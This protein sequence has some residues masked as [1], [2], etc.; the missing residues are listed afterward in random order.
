MLQ[1]IRL[2][3]RAFVIVGI[4]VIAAGFG[5][6]V[7]QADDPTANATM[8]LAPTVIALDNPTAPGSPNPS[9]PIRLTVTV[10][11]D[12]G[13]A[14]LPSGKQPILLNIY[15][16]NGGPLSPTT[17]RITSASDPSSSFVYD[18]SYFDNPMILTA[19]MGDA[20][21]STSIVAGNRLDPCN[22]P[23]SA[24][25]VTIPYSN[26]MR[27]LEHGFTVAVSVGGGPWHT[28]VE[29]DTGST[30]LVL[31]QGAMGPQAIGPG[32]PGS[33]EYY[34]SGY[35][36]VGNYWLTPVTIAIPQG[37]GVPKP[38][39]T[40]V[41]IEVFGIDKVECGSDV[42]SCT[43]PADQQKAIANFSLMGIGFDRGT[44][45]LSN[46]P[47]LQLAD[48][49]DGSMSPGY[50]IAPDRVDI[51]LDAADT[52]EDFRYVTLAPNDDMEGD[53]SGANG[54]FSFPAVSA[55]FCGSMLLDTGIDQMIFALAKGQRPPAVVDPSNS[56]LL[57]PGTAV[58]IATSTAPPLALFYGF[59][60]EPQTTS[61]T[62]VPTRIEWA[63][64]PATKP[65]IFFNIG[66]SPLA[67]FDY[68]Y[69]A[70]CGRVGFFDRLTAP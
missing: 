18:G 69:D 70:R 50:V 64:P 29:L 5:S 28:G 36:I 26:P 24:G 56:G 9:Q 30:G 17:A 15:Q 23:G 37:N 39:A 62:V 47:F 61:S 34:P 19:T 35:K 11:D 1:P 57:K 12:Q 65:P 4:V 2:G 33:R 43:P 7:A 8:T 20:S 16:P 55:M 54:C 31:D 13:H 60:Y 51:G 25:H 10:S 21:A 3:L 48:V 27:T 40:T 59:T 53:W 45:P 41:P 67:R 38:L 66:R 32:R 46:N 6:A 68:L 58:D 49:V 44:A 42:K 63:A 14:I 22:C 52:A